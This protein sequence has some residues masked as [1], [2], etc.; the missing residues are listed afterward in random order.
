MAVLWPYVLGKGLVA[1]AVIGGAEGPGKLVDLFYEGPP[2]LV[3]RLRGIPDPRPHAEP[4]AASL[5]E[6]EEAAN[7]T[8]TRFKALEEKSETH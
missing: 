5:R 7:G 8:G 1:S 3:R 2:R 4:D 6:A